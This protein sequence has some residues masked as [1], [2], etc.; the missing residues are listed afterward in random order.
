MYKSWQN[1]FSLLQLFTFSSPLISTLI[2]NRMAPETLDLSDRFSKLYQTSISPDNVRTSMMVWPKKSSDSRVNF[3]LILDLKSLSSSHTRTL[4]RSD[5]LWHSLK[6]LR[7]NKSW[8]KN[9]FKKRHLQIKLFVPFRIEFFWNSFSSFSRFTHLDG[10]I[11]IWS[12][13]LVFGNQAL[14]ANH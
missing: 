4:I 13:S 10:D 2:C 12:T 7:E 6:K 9:I 5:E 11:R 3:C 14:S 1:W 8:K